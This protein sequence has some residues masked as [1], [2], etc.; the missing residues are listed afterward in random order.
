MSKG[1]SPPAPLFQSG[2]RGFTLILQEAARTSKAA[3][4]IRLGRSRTAIS[5][6]LSGKYGA[7]CDKVYAAALAVLDKR[8]CPY[9]GAEV[10]AVYCHETNT[11]PT[12]TWDPSALAQRRMC[13]HCEHKQQEVTL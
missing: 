5:R 11:G 12:P 3:V 4:A 7:K 9:L 6:V 8:H 2:E 10:E 1:K 13:Q